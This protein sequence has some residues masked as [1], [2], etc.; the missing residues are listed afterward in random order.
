[1]Y[2]NISAAYKSG[3][4]YTCVSIPHAEVL[5]IAIYIMMGRYIGVSRKLPYGIH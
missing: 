3:T 2:T 4:Y 5:T 1:M